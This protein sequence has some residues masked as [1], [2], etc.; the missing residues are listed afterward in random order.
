MG[1]IS[2]NNSPQE[3]CT[4]RKFITTENTFGISYPFCL[5]IA[6]ISFSSIS[7]ELPPMGL[8]RALDEGSPVRLERDDEL[9]ARS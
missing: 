4:K 1:G 6:S 7:D 9:M 3:I 5:N 2:Y 8:G